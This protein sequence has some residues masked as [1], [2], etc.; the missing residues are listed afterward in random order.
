MQV[1]TAR[2]IPDPTI[3]NFF[4]LFFCLDCYVLFILV[5]DL[6]VAA[7]GAWVDRVNLI[8]R[9]VSILSSTFIREAIVVPSGLRQRILLTLIS[10]VLNRK[11]I[12]LAFRATQSG[13]VG[14][15]VRCSPLLWLLLFLFLIGRNRLVRAEMRGL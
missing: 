15:R 12:L 6:K 7:R 5:F 2:L 4:Q 11:Q 8:H 10:I 1:C 13:T 14:S 9:V 3:R